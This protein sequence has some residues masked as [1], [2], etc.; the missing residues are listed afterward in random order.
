ML[1]EK[2][3]M[4]KDVRIY[5][6]DVIY[7]N[8]YIITHNGK[9]IEI[10]HTAELSEDTIR[11]CT[12]IPIPSSCQLVP[13]MIDVHIHGA[14]GADTMDASPGALEAIATHLPMEG[15]TSFL[16][17]TITQSTTSIERALANVAE[18]MN[19]DQNGAEILGIHLEGPFISEKRAGAQPLAY[20]KQ[21]DVD[22][23]KKWQKIAQGIIKVVTLAPEFEGSPELLHYLKE[24]EVVASLGHSEATYED[25][26]NAITAGASHVTHLFNAMSGLHHREPGLAAAALMRDELF[27]EIIADGIHVHPEMIRLAHR[28]KSTAKVILITDS[29]RAKGMKPGIYDLGGQQVIVDESQATLQDGTLAGSMLAMNDAWRNFQSYTNCSMEDMIQMTAVN[30]A[31]QLK[32]YDR[33]GSIAVGKDA[34][35]VLRSKDAEIVMTFCKGTI[36]YKNGGLMNESHSSEKLR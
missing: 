3:M 27:V 31:K 32:V 18:C 25:V 15:T 17:T 2:P 9:I 24:T 35:L 34:D 14:A 23:F 4:L 13:G 7:D 29:I 19:L 11:N 12:I 33:K 10:G 36:A 5:G 6:E 28:Q 30:P 21:P 22:L 20:I 1:Q 16:A 26:H 8:G